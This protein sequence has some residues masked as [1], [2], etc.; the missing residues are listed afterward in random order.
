[1]IE[2]FSGTGSVGK[3]ARSTMG[4]RVLSIDSDPKFGADRTDNV[5]TLDYAKLPV[6]DYVWAS[7][8]CTTYSLAASWVHHRQKGTGKALTPAAKEGDRIL[9]KTLEMI[10][11]WQ[12]K[13]PRLRFCIENPRAYM[14]FQPSMRAFHR[15]TTSY[16]HF[17]WPLCKP[18]DFFS[19][20]PLDLPPAKC[21]DSPFRVGEGSWHLKIRDALGDRSST[22]NLGQIPPRLVRTILRQLKEAPRSRTSSPTKRSRSRSR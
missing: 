9:R 19:N 6:P 15:A 14:R 4:W 1:M 20:V 8:P 16:N 3:V 17:G 18:T 22:A 11:Y 21:G 5:M 10:S 13:N 7:P 2:L 12:R